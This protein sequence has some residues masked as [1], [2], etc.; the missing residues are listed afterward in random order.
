MFLRNRAQFR[1]L[2]IVVV[3]MVAVS[4]TAA[5]SGRDN[6]LAD[7]YTSATAATDVVIN[8][9]YYQ[10]GPG[11]DW[12]E[13]K[14]TGA[15]PV[16][17][18]TW[19]TCVFPAYALVGSATILDGDDFV[20]NPGEILTVQAWINFST[21]SELALYTNSNFGSAAS[22]VDYIQWNSTTGFRQSVAVAA[23]MWTNGD[24]VN[25]AGAGESV[26]YA[27]LNSGGGLLTLSSDFF[28]GSPTRGVD[29]N[30]VPVVETSWGKIK[31]TFQ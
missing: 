30:P 21:A 13:F 23:G 18:S 5:T 25:L 9:V 7:A 17:I 15:A 31:S 16:D 19:W 3:A 10:G 8:E 12:I 2:A 20:L 26:A 24:N 4:V 27:G 1:V 29:N 14:N 11:E 6:T 28:N 22:I